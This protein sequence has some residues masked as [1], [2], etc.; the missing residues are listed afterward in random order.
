MNSVND[1]IEF[2]NREDIKFIE[3]VLE[4]PQDSLKNNHPLSLYLR[5][6]T[7]W[8]KKWFKELVTVIKKLQN[9][10]N[11]NLLLLR[12]KLNDPERFREGLIFLYN[13][14]CFTEIGCSIK[15]IKEDNKERSVDLKITKL[16][17]NY[18]F[19]IECS[20]IKENE[21]E[22]NI[23]YT[24]SKISTKITEVSFKY[25]LKYCGSILIEYISQ[26]EI[27]NL[28]SQIEQTAEKAIIQNSAE[29]NNQYLQLAFVTEIEFE[30]LK[31]FIN[32]NNLRDNPNTLTHGLLLINV[33]KKIGLKPQTI[34]NVNN[35]N[36]IIDDNFIGY[37]H[38]LT[39]NIIPIL[40][41]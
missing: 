11:D 8:R 17:E 16:D 2:D 33:T 24:F 10:D 28:L 19:F 39:P 31:E 14:K 41:N 38:C 36:P 12:D 21:Q 37:L 1:D 35:E 20:E 15:F 32:K 27:D 34:A 29:L 7:P 4:I 25:N 9:D 13:Y 6:I 22:K 3:K 18:E 26:S 40:I 5:I 23:R 30:I